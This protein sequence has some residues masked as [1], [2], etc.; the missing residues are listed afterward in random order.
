MSSFLQYYPIELPYRD[1]FSNVFMGYKELDNI[2]S[3]IGLTTSNIQCGENSCHTVAVEMP[4]PDWYEQYSNTIMNDTESRAVWKE[5]LSNC[6]S[7]PPI[8]KNCFN[9]HAD[10]KVLKLNIC[11]KKSILFYLSH[12]FFNDSMTNYLSIW[13]Y[14]SWLR[15]VHSLQ[16]VTESFAGIGEYHKFVLADNLRQQISFSL[17]NCDT[18]NRTKYTHISC[19][20]QFRNKLD[21]VLFTYRAVYLNEDWLYTYESK[22]SKYVPV[23]CRT[24][25]EQLDYVYEFHR[26]S[27]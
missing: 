4:W 24:Y 8:P 6:F 21:T 17:P 3:T 9:H 18:E 15:L 10:E 27:V 22:C 19:P 5:V 26:T 11:K 7:G 14:D 12:N 20:E 25:F 13:L 2:T 1:I 23:N 16:K